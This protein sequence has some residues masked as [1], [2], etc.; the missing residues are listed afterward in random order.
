MASLAACSGIDYYAVPYFR[1]SKKYRRTR[2]RITSMVLY[3]VVTLL[4]VLLLSG[5]SINYD[6]PNLKNEIL[7]LVD[8]SHSNR[9]LEEQKNEFIKSVLEKSDSRF[10]VGIVTFGYNQVYAAE[11]SFD[12]DQVYQNYLKAKRPNDSATDI[13]S[14]LNYAKDRFTNPKAGKIILMTD[15]IETEGKAMS[16]ILSLASSGLKVDTVY[17][18]N[19]YDDEVQITSITAPDY[20]IVIGNT[21]SLSVTLKSSFAGSASLTLYDNDIKS[22]SKQ[23]ELKAGE[24]NFEFEYVFITPGAHRV[25]FEI[26]SNG[27]NLTQNNTYFSYLYLYVFD[28]VLIVD[29]DGQSERLETLIKDDYNVTVVNIT[30]VPKT[31]DQLREYDEVILMNVERKDMKDFETILY[32]YV[33]EHGGGLFTIGGDKAY[34]RKDLEKSDYQKM[35]PVEAINY[36][37]PLGLVIIID[38]SGSMYGAKL[39]MAKEGA[40]ACVNALNDR[41]YCGIITL[42]NSYSEAIGL[43]RVSEKDIILRAIANIGGGGGTVYS[44]AIQLAGN[45]LQALNVEKRHIIFISD[46]EPSDLP[47]EYEPLITNYYEK[48]GITMSTVFVSDPGSTKGEDVMIRIKEL[49]HG[50]YH[51]AAADPSSISLF[52]REDVRVPEI[53][54]YVPE[55]FTPKLKENSSIASG[56]VGAMPDLDGFY[57]T[58]PKNDEVT[59]LSGAFVPIYAQ[60]KYGKGRVGSFMCDLNGTWS[61]KFLTEDNGIRFIN[62]VIKGL[63]P[64]ESIRPRDIKASFDPKNYTT[65]LIIK[66]PLTEGNI[67]EVTVIDP[68]Q[69][70]VSYLPP[71]TGGYTKCLLTF[72]QPGIYEVN[73]IKKDKDKNIISEYTTHTTFSYSLEYDLFREIDGLL[74]LTNL[75]KDGKGMVIPLENPEKVFRDFITSNSYKYDPYIPLIIMAVILFLLD[76]AVRKFKFKWPWEIIRDYKEKKLLMQDKVKTK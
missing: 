40:T 8:L 11:F 10:Q 54:E 6:K 53:T 47:S 27:D 60:W 70:S 58:K 23:I 19:D 16:D 24:E 15:G 32:S 44:G 45:A 21:A 52:M 59:L 35:L 75:S 29:G 67:I 14:A 37:P 38:R 25:Y 69:Q 26:E 36:T 43:T 72:S 2:N 64:T 39:D 13:V 42:E 5:V 63:F 55:T 56:I 34:G 28:K 9:E 30:D 18:S 68:L 17:F 50:R 65:E 71:I 7:L 3:M 76:I 1:I 49:A 31:L 61:D 62:N 12:T 48:A 73:I 22:P 20:N 33:F 41:D 4:S 57:G 66:T 74:F 46:G 51:N